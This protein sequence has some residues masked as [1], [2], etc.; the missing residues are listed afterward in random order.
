[1]Q[2][3]MQLMRAIPDEE[4]DDSDAEGDGDEDAEPAEQA[5]AGALRNPASSTATASS[6]AVG[7]T[8]AAGQK[9]GS[10]LGPLKKKDKRRR[11][12]IVSYQLPVTVTRRVIASTSSAA[13]STVTW[14]VLW[15][16]CRS[17]MSGLR[18]LRETMDVRWV[19]Y[20]GV[21][22]LNQAEKASLEAA[23]AAHG[24]HPVYLSPELR[25]VGWCWC[26]HVFDCT[27]MCVMNILL[28]WVNACG[29]VCFCVLSLQREVF[30]PVL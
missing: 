8:L 3:M 20:P 1:M 16:D 14:D 26:V 29:C 9:S 30:L 22:P 15:D 23:L 17:F 2:N 7:S 5:L 12:I 28:I 27:L 21:D 10:R 18:V 24:C 6:A 25:C 19:G 13:A 4:G 11:L